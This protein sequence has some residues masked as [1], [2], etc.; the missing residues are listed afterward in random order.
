MRNLVSNGAR[1]QECAMSIKLKEVSYYGR[2]RFNAQCDTSKLIMSL[3]SKRSTFT[4]DD[5]EKFRKAG[6]KVEVLHD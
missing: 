5:V 3:M 4:P 6:W 2:T 1:T